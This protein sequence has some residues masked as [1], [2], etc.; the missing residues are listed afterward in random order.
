MGLFS[1]LF[2]YLLTPILAYYLLR[3][4][5]IICEKINGIFP[6]AYKQRIAYLCREIDRVLTKFIRGH[7]LLAL[8]VGILMAIGL[9]IIN[10]KFAILLGIFAGVLDLVPYFGPIL[11]AIP[12]V[13]IA[14]LDSKSKAIY[15]IIIT[16][17]IQQLE[18]NYL[19]PKIL[20]ESVG[21]HPLAIIFV[22]LAGGHLFGFLGLVLAVPAAAIGK[23]I[24]NY[25]LDKSIA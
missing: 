6:C 23:I 21:L 7:L 5:A 2:I 14:L 8:I 10:V 4:K 18:S 11:G 13:A 16:V 3:D 15:V 12:A 17:L 9:S 19:S 1:G 25:Y 20:G 24:I 22:V